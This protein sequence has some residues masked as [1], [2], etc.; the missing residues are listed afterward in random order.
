MWTNRVTHGQSYIHAESAN[1][2]FE[3]F[4]SDHDRTKNFYLFCFKFIF[5]KYKLRMNI[6]K[7]TCLIQSNKIALRLSIVCAL[8]LLVLFNA[9]KICV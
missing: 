5:F 9:L 8:T 3:Q 7:K 6:Q 4:Q 1:E 2:I